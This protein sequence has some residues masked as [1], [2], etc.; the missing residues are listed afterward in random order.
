MIFIGYLQRKKIAFLIFF[1]AFYDFIKNIF[2]AG[3]AENRH[4][5]LW[6]NFYLN[7]LAFAPKLLES[8]RVYEAVDGRP[9][10]IQCKF[11]ASPMANVSWDGVTIRGADHYMKV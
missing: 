7:L 2:F 9:F 11:F 5:F 8:P 10:N 6:T 1:S 4:G 3:K